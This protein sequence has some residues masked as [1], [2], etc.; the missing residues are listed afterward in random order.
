[1]ELGGTEDFDEAEAVP[2]SH[3]AGTNSLCHCKPGSA[4]L[5]VS[6]SCRLGSFS[7]WRTK[8]RPALVVSSAACPAASVAFTAFLWMLPQM[9]LL[10][11]LPLTVDPQR[12]R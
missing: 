5:G 2:Q 3:G 11:S 4:S 7:M 1:M 8:E 6:L 9:S 12:V 10:C